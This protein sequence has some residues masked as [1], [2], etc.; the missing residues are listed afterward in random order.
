[1]DRS[2]P[3]RWADTTAFRVL[4]ALS[5]CAVLPV[6]GIGV[7]VTA[8]GGAAL[9]SAPQRIEAGQVAFGLLAL[10]GALGLVGYVRAL[11]GVRAPARHSVAAT[12]LF[13]A[14]GVL[15]ALAVAA[16]V[17]ATLVEVVLLRRW[18]DAAPWLGLGGLFV[19]ANLIWALAGVASLQ[20]LLRRYAETT[21][22]LFDSLPV[23]LLC[24]AITLAT[25]AALATATL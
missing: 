7:L 24:V 17:A 8:I 4:L 19:A 16:F 11:L 3:E 2:F 22:R 15:A 20:R 6:L 9:V 23:V 25:A 13:V 18:A 5:G 10:G 14:A 12:L 21:G 1:M